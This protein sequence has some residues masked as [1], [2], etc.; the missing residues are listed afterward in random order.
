MRSFDEILE[1]A[2]ER[3]G[4]RAAVL[5][6]IDPPLG[7]QALAAIPDDRWLSQMAKAVFQAGFN[8]KVIENKWPGFEEAFFGF[9]VGR[10]AMMSDDWFDQ[11]VQ[12]TRIVRNAMKIRSV[13]ENAV[14]VQETAA[15]AG[16][17][18]RKIADWPGEDYAGLLRWLAKEGSRLGGT[19]A[20]YFLRFM[21]KDSYILSRDVVG[22][23]IAEGVIDK[24]PTS[25]RA[26]AAVQEAFNAWAEE[27]DQSLKVISR[28]LAQSIG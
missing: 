18:G 27:S 11:L 20:Q 1:I 4:G 7:S 5:D 6:G 28:V 12:D 14:F 2:A 3:K 15:E 26:M 9:D 23:L 17:F 25:Q 22:R 16:S 21:G 8:W 24:P 19:S 13:Q 10:V